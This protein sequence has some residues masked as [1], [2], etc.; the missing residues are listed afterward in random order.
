MLATAVP[1]AWEGRLGGWYEK[2]KSGV[3]RAG[4]QFLPDRSQFFVLATRRPLG[5]GR[6]AG[7]I[8]GSRVIIAKIIDSI[9]VS[10]NTSL[11]LGS[12]SSL[13]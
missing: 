3:S 11:A 10:N 8:N 9:R 12:E 1:F 5:L 6:E 13:R 2:K 7:N 4:V